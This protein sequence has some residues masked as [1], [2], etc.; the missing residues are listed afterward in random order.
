[1]YNKNEFE[2]VILNLVN[3]AKD[4]LVEQKILKPKIQI[5]IDKNIINITDN[6]GGISKKEQVKIFEPYFSTKENHDG[7]GLYIAKMI[8]EKEMKGRL[9]VDANKTFSKF[10]IKF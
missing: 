8:I 6:A 3:N 1:M 10:T 2:Q 7:I 9:L 4:A 5:T